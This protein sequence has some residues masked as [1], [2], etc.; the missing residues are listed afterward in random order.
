MNE[1]RLF[2]VLLAPRISEKSTLVIGQYV[3]EVFSDATKLEI[4]RAV[5]NRFDVAVR[6][7]HTCNVKGKKTR[8]RQVCGRRKNWKK[9]YV[10]LA[11]GSK[12]DIASGE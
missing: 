5:E 10:V 7:V 4:K 2:K 1:E 3:F 6:S 11:P 8:F 9:A 12:I